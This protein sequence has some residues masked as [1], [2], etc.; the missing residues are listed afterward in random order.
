MNRITSTNFND[1]L[2]AI[3][4]RLTRFTAPQIERLILELEVSHQE[5]RPKYVFKFAVQI[6]PLVQYNGYHSNAYEALTLT[7]HRMASAAR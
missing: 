2:G 5:S 7:L 3:V 6:P 4:G 1:R